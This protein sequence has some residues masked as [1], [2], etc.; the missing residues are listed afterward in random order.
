MNLG[1]IVKENPIQKT[2]GVIWDSQSDALKYLVH[3]VDAQSTSTKRKLLSEIA[4]IFDPLGLLVPVNLFAKVLIQD[5]WK[6]QIKWD[7]SLPQNI[8]STWKSFTEQLPILQ[9]FSVSRKFLGENY[10]D[11][12]LHGF[13]DACLHGYGASLYVRSVDSNG[14]I[15]VN[16]ICSKS[17]VAPLSGVTI[18]RLELCAASI[19]KKLY[20]EVKA[21]LEIPLKRITFWSDST[22]VLC[23]LKK[24]LHVLRVFE[25]NRVSDIQSLGDEVEWRYIRYEDNPADSLSRDNFLV[26]LSKISFGF[27]VLVG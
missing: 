10:V 21:Q 6:A 5:C 23:W 22:I 27:R 26:I 2:L 20:V 1:C 12:E 4:K 16:L 15:T 24:A 8:H 25:S 19:L 11:I 3:E 18:P 17:R 9:N 13:C 14:K 7:E